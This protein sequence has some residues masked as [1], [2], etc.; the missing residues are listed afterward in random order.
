MTNFRTCFR[1]E[2]ILDIFGQHFSLASVSGL[3]EIWEL[4]ESYAPRLCFVCLFI[5][6]L[7][8]S[9]TSNVCDADMGK[10]HLY[11]FDLTRSQKALIRF[12]SWFTMALQHLIQINSRLEMDFWNLIQIGS[13]LKAFDP[14]QLTT[15]KTFQ[16][17]DSNQ[18]M[19]QW[20]CS[21]SVSHDVFWAFNSTVDLE[22]LFWAF[23][24]SIDFT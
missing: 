17:L 6:V 10:T 14:Y 2:H 4:S 1:Q 13:R 22:D 15:K 3:D 24:A 18:P 19:I 8:R 12:N 5:G 11:W 7:G 23:H 9:D 16:N 21:L 20:C